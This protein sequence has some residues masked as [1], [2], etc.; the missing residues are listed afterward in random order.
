MACDGPALVDRQALAPEV[1]RGTLTDW[2]HVGGRCRRIAVLDRDSPAAGRRVLEFVV[3]SAG[4]RVLESL[5]V[6]ASG[7]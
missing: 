2:A 7:G 5:D 6:V 4:R 1:Y 3:G